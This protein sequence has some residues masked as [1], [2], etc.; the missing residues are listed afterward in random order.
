MSSSSQSQNSLFRQQQRLY[1]SSI[2]LTKT[3]VP[4]LYTQPITNEHNSNKGIY[5]LYPIRSI[6]LFLIR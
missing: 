6:H 5:L 3:K 4:T 1:R 2:Y